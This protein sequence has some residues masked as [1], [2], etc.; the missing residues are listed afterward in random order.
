MQ[1]HSNW[2]THP[3]G[4]K[5]HKDGST[6]TVTYDD[7]VHGTVFLLDVFGNPSAW[8]EDRYTTL[9]ERWV[10]AGVGEDLAYRDASQSGLTDEPDGGWTP[11]VCP[12]QSMLPAMCKGGTAGVSL[13]SSSAFNFGNWANARL[14]G[15]C[16]SQ[17]AGSQHMDIMRA[18]TIEQVQDSCKLCRRS[19]ESVAQQCR[20]R[21]RP[22]PR[23]CVGPPNTR[24]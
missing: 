1:Q 24:L 9:D 14:P 16:L 22:A 8:I 7:P 18:S 6:L 21:H 2:C 23:V 15:F 13:E 19:A 5:S 20:A 17:T 4:A 10:S 12:A 11:G 3:A